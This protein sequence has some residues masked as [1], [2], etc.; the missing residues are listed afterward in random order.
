MKKRNVF[1]QI[2][3]GIPVSNGRWTGDPVDSMWIPDDDFV[4]ANTTKG[5]FYFRNSDHTFPVVETH[6]F[7]I[8]RLL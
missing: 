8:Q 5:L 4:P 6:G 1:T 3:L 2:F 7:N